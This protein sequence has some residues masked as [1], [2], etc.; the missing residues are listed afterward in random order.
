MFPR[1]VAL[2]LVS[3]LSVPMARA[4]D[5]GFVPLFPSN[6]EPKGWTVGTW[7]DVSK[8]VKDVHWTVKDG[9]LYSSKARGNWLMSDKEY[10]DFELRLDF[11]LPRR[12]RCVR[13][14]PPRPIGLDD[15][16]L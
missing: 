2:L 10:G 3:L 6:G 15:D 14:R 5:D 1:C 8:P 12:L 11:K 13:R 7:N 9:V 16:L 4:D